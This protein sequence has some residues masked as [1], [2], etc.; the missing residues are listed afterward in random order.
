VPQLFA[1]KLQS[2]SFSNLELGYALGQKLSRTLFRRCKA[3][4]GLK[5]LVFRSCH[6]A[7]DV[8]RAGIEKLVEEV[9]W[10]N[11]TMVYSDGESESDW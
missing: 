7:S 2:L 8:D 10:V 9:N 11:T 4:G 1:P 6:V 5:R 3:K